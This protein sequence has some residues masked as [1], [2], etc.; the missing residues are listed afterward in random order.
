[1]A[2]QALEDAR[3]AKARRD[4][5]AQ[6]SQAARRL[7][8]FESEQQWSQAL[9]D[10][11]DGF[12]R[13][14]ALFAVNGQYLELRATR[15]L[16]TRLI[17]RVLIGAA[18]AFASAVETKDT[19]VAVR[20]RGELSEP[21]ANVVGEDPDQRFYLFPLI[22]RDRVAAVLYADTEVETSALDLIATCGAAVLEGLGRDRQ[23]A[24]LHS[25]QP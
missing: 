7:R 24:N 1:M 10:V 19:V 14:A 23:A 17:E 6:L 3:I 8:V 4:L 18:P 15:N 2:D 21:V 25:I 12:C 9:A 22:V 11:T 5:T 13:R 20:T 16:E